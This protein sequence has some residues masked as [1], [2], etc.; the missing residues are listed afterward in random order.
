MCGIV[1]FKVSFDAQ[2]C[3]P[4]LS[5]RLMHFYF[6]FSQMHFLS[7]SFNIHNTFLPWALIGSAKTK[8][9]QLLASLIYNYCPISIVVWHSVT[10]DNAGFLWLKLTATFDLMYIL[11]KSPCLIQ[12]FIHPL[13]LFWKQSIDS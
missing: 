7:Y 5:A 2:L 10:F 6:A 9:T 8:S 12:L 1:N 11:L 13:N 3:S 4:I